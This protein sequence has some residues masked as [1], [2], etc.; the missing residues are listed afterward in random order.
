MI[1]Y[2][3]KVSS[4]DYIFSVEHGHCFQLRKSFF[5]ILNSR[6][7]ARYG[8]NASNFLGQIPV[9]EVLVSLQ[10][11]RAVASYAFVVVALDCII[12]SVDADVKHPIFR[13][14]VLMDEP[15]H[16]TW[17][18]CRAEILGSDEMVFVEVSLAC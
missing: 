18:I 6:C 10:L 1:P 9:N 11:D 15:V 4:E 3:R 16:R 13:V 2:R 8:V 17:S 7:L 14:F 12:E 5:Y